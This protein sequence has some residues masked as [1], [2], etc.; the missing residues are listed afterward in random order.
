MI[1]L[2]AGL[3]AFNF[4]GGVFSA[5]LRL[6][7]RL[8]LYLAY[9]SLSAIFHDY[10]SL[11]IIKRLVA[12]LPTPVNHIYFLQLLPVYTFTSLFG[13]YFLLFKQMDILASHTVIQ[14]HLFSSRFQFHLRC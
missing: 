3:G 13:V 2:S 14:I 12:I 6:V 1:G 5:Q 8:S 9:I 7:H 10:K 4:V 11:Y